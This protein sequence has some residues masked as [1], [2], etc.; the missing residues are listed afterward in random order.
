MKKKKA[1][2]KG[3]Q[4]GAPAY[5]ANIFSS[6]GNLPPYGHLDKYHIPQAGPY[7]KPS[8]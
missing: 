4:C 6:K 1:K 7:T 3:K 2:L 8:P 5:T